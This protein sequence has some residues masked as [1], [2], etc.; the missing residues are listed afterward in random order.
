M[1]SVNSTSVGAARLVA[2]R[3]PLHSEPELMVAIP[4]GPLRL[5]PEDPPA[6]PVRP[7]PGGLLHESDGIAHKTRDEIVL[8]KQQLHVHSHFGARRWVHSGRSK[9]KPQRGE[10]KMKKKKRRNSGRGD[11]SRLLLP[12][13]PPNYS[14]VTLSGKGDERETSPS[15]SGE[16]A[17]GTHRGEVA[18]RGAVPAALPGSVRTVWWGVWEQLGGEGGRLWSERARVNAAVC[19]TW[20]EGRSKVE[21]RALIRAS[22]PLSTHIHTHTHTHRQ[23]TRWLC[24][25]V[26]VCGSHTELPLGERHTFCVCCSTT[27]VNIIFSCTEG[28]HGSWNS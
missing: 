15:W 9:Q 17:S 10:K 5:R 14:G 3:V 24:V 16:S 23:H 1:E 19:S 6:V 12:T 7:A 4:P 27:T 11:Q 22:P 18:E 2:L 26:C 28:P 13:T 8:Q 20:G 21:L 25:C